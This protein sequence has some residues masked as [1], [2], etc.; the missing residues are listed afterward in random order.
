SLLKYV[1]VICHLMNVSAEMIIRDKSPILKLE[2]IL[3]CSIK[4]RFPTP[5][6]WLK[7]VW[8]THEKP[9]QT[10]APTKK[11]ENTAFSCHW[12]SN[13]GREVIISEPVG[14]GI[15]MDNP[16]ASLP[17]FFTNSSA[18]SAALQGAVKKSPTLE[19][20]LP[21]GRIEQAEMPYRIIFEAKIV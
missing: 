18:C 1:Y 16:P 11:A 13:E 17:D 12:I 5:C 15:M 7:T 3:K 14:Q 19:Q 4:H 20:R 8:N 6:E 10:I 2:R 9:R 21:L